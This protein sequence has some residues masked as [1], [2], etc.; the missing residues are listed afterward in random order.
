MRIG[1]VIAAAVFISGCA[2]TYQAPTIQSVNAVSNTTASKEQVLMAAK[3]ALVADGYQIT[4]FDDAAGVIS[5][6]PKQVKL[7]PRDADCGKTLGLDYLLDN[8]TSTKVTMGVIAYQGRY[9][10]RASIAGD[11]RPGEVSQNMDLTCVSRG[12]LEALLMEQITAGI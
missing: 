2:A 7:T 3:R 10:V 8:R 1:I 9:V 6:A 12:N 4:S 5:T 11:Y